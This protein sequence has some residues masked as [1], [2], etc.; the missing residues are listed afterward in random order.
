MTTDRRI[1]TAER[2][3]RAAAFLPSKLVP[4]LSGTITDGYWIDDHRFFYRLSEAG[5]DG[6]PVALPMI[7]D[8]AVNTAAPVLPIDVLATLLSRHTEAEISTVELAAAEFD[9][10][11]ANTLLVM[12]AD[13][14]YHVA[15]DEPAL[16]KAERMNSVP[17]LHSP[18][19]KRACFLKDH[20]V[21]VRDRSTGTAEQLFED[22]EQLFAFGFA[23]ESGIAPVSGR[24][25]LMPS[26]LWSADAEWFA[27]H[28]ID[29]RHLPEVGLIESAP[30]GGGRPVPHIF[31][32]VTPDDESPL[33][34]F[35][36]VH[37]PSGRKVSAI[38]RKVI[39]QVMS[40]FTFRQCWIAG[41]RFYFLDFDRFSSEV[42]LVELNLETGAE[43]TVL[44]E[45]AEEGW[46]DLHPVIGGQ[47]IVRTLVPSNEVIWFSE[48]DGWGHLYLYDLATG[49]FKNRI[50]QG[51]WMVR[52]IVHVDDARRRVL[53]LASGLDSDLDA[54]FRCLCGVN[55]DGT[56]FQRLFQTDRDIEIRPD[57]VFGNEQAKPFRPSYAPVGVSGNGRYAFASLAS[58]ET[59]TKAVLIELDTGR[60]LLLAEADMAPRWKAPKPRPFDALAADGVTR[61]HGAMYVPSD[62]E[63]TQSYPIV[64]FI[65]PGPQ[66]NWFVRR[67]PS[68]VGMLLQSV[69]EVG[70]VGV[71]VESRG[72]PLRS[73]AFH[74]AG[75]GKLHEPQ[76]SDHAAVLEQLCARHAFLDPDRIGIF[77]Q[78]GG[79]YATARA[80]FDY[81]EVFKVGVSVCGNHDSRNYTGHWLNKYGG[82]PG[83]SER[84]DQS[85]ISVAH[86][87]VGEL[88]LIHG[89]MDENV[90]VG[91]TLALSAALIEAGK[92]FDQLI[93]PNAGH[94]V[95]VESAYVV[96][97]LW[98]FFCRH[99]LHAAPPADFVLRY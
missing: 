59:P 34:E 72:T 12:F 1:L 26:G 84:D 54:A 92:R 32:M 17:A 79:G 14:A 30:A 68:H 29:E 49:E 48:R 66:Q 58:A 46:I 57:P 37:V 63:A 13:F 78:S 56:G 6:K 16:V 31:R 90:H 9:M 95:L 60:Q 3:E 41:Q 83:T 93:V 85:N 82:R 36:A 76:L 18:D 61:L 64:D 53:F 88:L 8:A 87:L 69:A 25:R 27:T 45:T 39:P 38:H 62:F 28:R 50:T 99:L 75:R 4:Q 42:S 2:Y 81:P 24:Q 35:T 65:Y 20:T 52:E 7:A 43:R 71:I 23:P 5:P 33:V 97:R 19:G 10:P 47:P 73:R 51:E 96:Q 11:N 74:Q 91:H 98:D 67:F 70:M 86:K 94:G 55:F 89:D 22:G 40:P 15:L 21:W 80:L 77:G 44:N